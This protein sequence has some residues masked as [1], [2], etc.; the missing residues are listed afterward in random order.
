MSDPTSRM[1]H[2]TITNT[3]DEPLL[4]SFPVGVG[5][6]EV[7]RLVLLPGETWANI[8]NKIITFELVDHPPQQSGA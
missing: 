4:L 2:Y 8:G 5:G 1:P 7:K 3:H 6:H